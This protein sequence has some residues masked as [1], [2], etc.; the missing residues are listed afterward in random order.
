MAMRPFPGRGRFMQV[1][2]LFEFG[3][4]LSYTSF[5]YK[6]S[7]V[8]PATLLLDATAA[9]GGGGEEQD[10]AA[11]S[12]VVSVTVTNAGDTYSGRDAALLFLTQSF[13]R[14][15]PE[16]KRLAAFEKTIKPI[17]KHSCVQCHGAKTAEGNIRIDTL[18]PNLLQGQDVAWWLEVLG[19]LSKGEMPPPDEVEMA[20]ADRAAVV[21]WLSREL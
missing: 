15:T 10:L 2:A 3:H 11:A 20:D 1:P 8:E 19:V 16:V 6:V 5:D 18:D 9:G 21:A 7:A 14:I 17:L 12:V 13:R 4:G